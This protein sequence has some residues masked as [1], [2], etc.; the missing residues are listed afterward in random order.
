MSGFALY[1]D[2]FAVVETLAG[3]LELTD[4]ADVAR[5]VRWLDALFAAAVTGANAAEM[6]RRIAAETG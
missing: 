1:D 5:H 6:C 4:P 2:D 3:E